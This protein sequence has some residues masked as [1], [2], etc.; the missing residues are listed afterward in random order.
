MGRK[1]KKLRRPHENQNICCHWL[2]SGLFKNQ[3]V[4]TKEV[5]D[6]TSKIPAE[7]NQPEGCNTLKHRTKTF[8]WF[9]VTLPPA[10]S[11][12]L[13][14]AC[15]SLIFQKKLK[16]SRKKTQV[17]TENIFWTEVRENR[18]EIIS[19]QSVE[20]PNKTKM[21]I[22]QD[23]EPNRRA[24][25]PEYRALPLEWLSFSL[26]I[27]L[28]SHFPWIKKSICTLRSPLCSPRHF[29]KY[30]PELH[31]G[32][33]LYCPAFLV[34]FNISNMAISTLFHELGK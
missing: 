33:L 9:Y 20:L 18:K 5:L 31:Q 8:L 30:D 19:V 26:G 11:K 6:S 13:H 3:R 16:A 22:E 10:N 29:R 32:R 21:H 2:K 34:T 7:Q 27:V 25:Q 14:K 15:D 23:R 1:G 28:Q 17:H 24:K 12:L 4:T